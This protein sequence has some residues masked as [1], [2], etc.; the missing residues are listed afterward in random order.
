MMMD[1]AQKHQARA[2]DAEL[3]EVWFRVEKDADRYPESKSWEGL[4]ARREDTGF[5]LESVPFYLKNVSRGD[6]VAATAGRFLE[7]TQVV[8]R[9]GHNTYRLLLK[10]IQPDDP[11]RTLNELI[12]LGLAVEEEH[13]LLI[14]VDVPPT[15]N[16]M[17]IDSYLVAQ[18]ESGRWEI[19]D[20]YLSSIATSS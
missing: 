15:V 5:R 12:K 1:E 16:Q 7:F 18:K 8:K 3:I 6:V 14:A 13:G 19:Q 10:R 4:L 20:G 2:D 9:G 17:A 11:G